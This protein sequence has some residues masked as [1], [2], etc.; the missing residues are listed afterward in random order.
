MLLMHGCTECARIGS[1]LPAVQL[2]YDSICVL[3]KTKLDSP[4]SVLK[5]RAGVELIHVAVDNVGVHSPVTECVV[6]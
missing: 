2:T 4:Q 6:S 5:E 1:V 3:I